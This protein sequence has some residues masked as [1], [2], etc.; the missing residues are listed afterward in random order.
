VLKTLG[1]DDYRVRL[2]FRDLNS[3]KYVGSAETWQ[4]A[5]AALEQVCLQMNLPNMSVER[6]EGRLLWPKADFRRGRLHR[7]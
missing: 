5:E 1:L 7:S 6:G 2:G 4:R 3:D